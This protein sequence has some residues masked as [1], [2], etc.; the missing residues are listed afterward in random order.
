[1]GGYCIID[2]VPL[3]EKLYVVWFSNSD[4]SRVF[5]NHGNHKLGSINV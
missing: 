2:R 5:F 1:M 4:S 3:S